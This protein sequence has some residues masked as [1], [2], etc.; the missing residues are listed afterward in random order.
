MLEQSSR[1]APEAGG[2]PGVQ[3][4]LFLPQRHALPVPAIEGAMLQLQRQNSTAAQGCKSRSSG[5]GI[6]ESSSRQAAATRTV[7]RTSISS[8]QMHRTLT[9]ASP[10][11]GRLPHCARRCSR[12]TRPFLTPPPPPR[13]GTHTRRVCGGPTT[14][15]AICTSPASHKNDMWPQTSVQDVWLSL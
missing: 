9:S 12:A 4:I 8:T 7:R 11:P 14:A 6:D 13:L 1:S 2:E 10:P 15:A 5:N 3:H